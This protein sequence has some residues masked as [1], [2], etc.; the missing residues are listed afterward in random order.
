MTADM[1]TP[2][3]PTD[4]IT[5]L[6]SK[7]Q[8]G[9]QQPEDWYLLQA[10]RQNLSTTL[11]NDIA[12]VPDDQKV[13]LLLHMAEV[14]YFTDYQQMGH[15]SAL[16][17]TV[18][19]IQ[20]KARGKVPFQIENQDLYDAAEFFVMVTERPLQYPVGDN[21]D[22]LGSLKNINSPVVKNS[23]LFKWLTGL[24]K[25]ILEAAW[26]ATSQ[27]WRSEYEKI[28][29]EAG[30][31]SKAASDLSSLCGRESQVFHT[32]PRKGTDHQD[33]LRLQMAG[34][35]GSYNKA[36]STANTHL[37]AAAKALAEAKQAIE[38]AVETAHKAKEAGKT[39]LAE[40]LGTQTAVEV[41]LAISQ[42]GAPNCDGCGTLTI[43]RG[44]AY[45][46]PNC[47]AWNGPVSSPA[48]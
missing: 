18:R 29:G 14:Y 4:A 33:A 32:L 21:N 19:D 38:T 10:Y 47:H 12:N 46:C 3:A 39:R 6:I 31:A 37:A 28:L 30:K 43:R 5:R 44:G 2:L 20:S 34:T 25:P 27:S 40:L 13:S 45:W 48:Q 17:S 15:D 11:F 24:S 8:A 16:C 41:A 22:V 36:M 23:P 1:F 42:P 7:V 35:T 9:T 26:Y